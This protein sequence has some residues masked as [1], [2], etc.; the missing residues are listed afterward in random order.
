MKK[1][2]LFF[3]LGFQLISL[4][5]TI[6]LSQIGYPLY[7]KNINVNRGLTVYKND[8][9]AFTYIT[10]SEYYNLGNLK[11]SLFLEIKK[12]NVSKFDY[13]ITCRNCNQIIFNQEIINDSIYYAFRYKEDLIRFLISY[14]RNPHGMITSAI[15]NNFIRDTV[16]GFIRL[17]N[18]FIHYTTFSTNDLSVNFAIVDKNFNG[19]IDDSDLLSISS[20]NYFT[21][22]ESNKSKLVKDVNLISINDQSFQVKIVDSKKF[23]L[24]IT[25]SKQNKAPDITFHSIIQDAKINDKLVSEYLK[26]KPF[27]VIFYW[28]SRYN[29]YKEDF[30]KLSKLKDKAEIISIYDVEKLPNEILGFSIAQNIA[31]T[32]INPDL[33]GEFDLNGYPSFMLIDKTGIVFSN[34]YNLDKISEFMK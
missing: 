2:L 13:D 16:I 22:V 14:E 9:V 21:T 25:P 30:E 8:S 34:E 11:D 7:Q 20:D 32:A 12:S 17:K 6:N 28:G 26:N 27:L 15:N 4:S 19:R 10:P 23:S 29:N 5:Q 24:K 31:I 1:T 33:K 3:L 18:T